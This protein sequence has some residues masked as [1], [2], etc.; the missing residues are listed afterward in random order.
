MLKLNNNE[1]TFVTFPNN[2]RRLDLNEEHLNENNIMT[3]KYENDSS[4]FELLLADNVMTQLNHTYD[5]VITYMPYSRM[6]RVEKT[7]TAFSLDALTSLL[8]KQLQK[9]KKVYVFDPHSPMTLEKLK[10]YGLDAGELDYSLA[11]DVVSTTHV[12]INKSWV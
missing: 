11:D 3:W 12:D 4:I 1:V 6:D 2:E 7:N 8:A 10:E 9:V 5:L